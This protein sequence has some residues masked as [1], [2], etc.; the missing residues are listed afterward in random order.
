MKKILFQGDS[1]TDCGRDREFDR[2]M[3][4]GYATNVAQ[5]LGYDYPGQYEFI[6]RGIGGNRIV[7]VYARIK[8][9]IINIVPDYMS[10]LI[11]VNDTWH[12]FDFQNGVET[13]KFEKIYDML[14]SEIKEA[15]PNIK[16]IILEPYLMIGRATEN[17]FNEFKADV[18]EKASVAKKIAAKHNLKFVPLQEKFDAMEKIVSEPYWTTDGVHPANPGHELIAREWIK[19]FE[20][21][22]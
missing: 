3:G 20:E 13:D 15:L 4:T 16:I 10:L 1:I 11:G 12:E 6:N 5:S 2:S 18:L 21:I 17:K 19:A 9:D 8:R 22:K 7:D 14:I